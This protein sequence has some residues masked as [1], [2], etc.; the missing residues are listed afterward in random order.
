MDRQ[1]ARGY[2]T[3]AICA[4]IGTDGTLYTMDYRCNRKAVAKFTLNGQSTNPLNHDARIQA[5]AILR[6]HK[7]LGITMPVMFESEFAQA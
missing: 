5:R 6:A 4:I 2:A 1:I 3:N 7:Y